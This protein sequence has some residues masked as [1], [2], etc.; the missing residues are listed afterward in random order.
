M[1]IEFIRDANPENVAIRA[2]DFLSR[3]L[4]ALAGKETLLLVSGGSSL[5]TFEHMS[6]ASFR[7]NITV[8]Q[9]DERWTSHQGDLNAEAF[10]KTLFS[11][12][13]REF[14]APFV[15]IDTSLPSVEESARAYEEYLKQ[16][17]TAWHDSAIVAVLGIG[18][19]GHIAGIMPN[20]TDTN[21]FNRD[22]Y[23]TR[24]WYRGYDTEGVGEFPSRVTA[25]MK[26][27]YQ[28]V[29]VAFVV[30]AGGKKRGA[31]ERLYAPEGSLAQTPARILREMRHVYLFS[32]VEGG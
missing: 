28:E 32:D 12:K 7:S 10:K 24:A 8:G 20:T 21:V 25:T 22:F 19:D 11:K 4:L 23:D 26:F 30:C 2:G 13:I 9:I 6:D 15:P 29:H 16:W 17:K 14:G 27:L 31:L 1:A 18:E 5:G 3:E